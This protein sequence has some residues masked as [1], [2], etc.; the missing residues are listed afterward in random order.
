MTILVRFCGG[1]NP[2]IDRGK[3]LQN[4]QKNES[5]LEFKVFT[6]VDEVDTNSYLLII[7]GCQSH[8]IFPPDDFTSSQVIVVAGEYLD[9]KSCSE[10]KLVGEIIE[11]ILTKIRKG[12]LP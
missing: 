1:C 8:C 2:A 7:N 6:G 9:G 12:G 11:K 5:E 3:L 4:L 10:D